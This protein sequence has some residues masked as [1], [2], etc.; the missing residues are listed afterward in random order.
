ML[1]R[2]D[3]FEGVRLAVDGVAD[4]KQFFE[5]AGLGGGPGGPGNMGGGSGAEGKSLEDMFYQ[6]EMEISKGAFTRQFTFAVVYAWVKLREQ[7][8]SAQFSI[9]RPSPLYR[10]RVMTDVRPGNSKHYLDC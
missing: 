4:Y 8:S 7:V 2:A 10:A 9:P 6:K 1:S 3:D 5:A